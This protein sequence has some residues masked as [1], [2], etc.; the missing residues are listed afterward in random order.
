M[1][2]Q[3]IVFGGMVP[4]IYLAKNCKDPQL[5]YKIECGVKRIKNKNTNHFIRLNILF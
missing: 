1:P 4:S 5:G 2:S 3:F